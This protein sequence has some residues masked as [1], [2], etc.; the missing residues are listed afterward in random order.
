MRPTAIVGV[1]WCD[2]L[3]RYAKMAKLIEVILGIETI[4]DPKH[5]A[6]DETRFPYGKRRGGGKNF[7]IVKYNQR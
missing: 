4:G 3:L 5:I 1:A 2:T 6:L 7:P